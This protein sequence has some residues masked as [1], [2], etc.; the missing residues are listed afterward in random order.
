MAFRSEWIEGDGIKHWKIYNRV[1][2]NGRDERKSGYPLYS[3]WDDSMMYTEKQVR[4]LVH[5]VGGTIQEFNKLI[6]RKGKAD[7]SK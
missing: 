4:E 2:P 6:E 7:D 3:G 5:E 1:M